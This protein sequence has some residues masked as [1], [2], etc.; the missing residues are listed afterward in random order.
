[1]IE[2]FIKRIAAN[3]E[4]IVEYCRECSS[5]K[6]AHSY[7][8]ITEKYYDLKNLFFTSW[9]KDPTKNRSRSNISKINRITIDIDF[10]KQYKAR[11][12]KDI[13]DEEIIGIWMNI[14][15]MLREEY[16]DDYW[17]WNFIVFSWN[18][19]HIHYIWNIYEIKSEKDY[20]LFRETT[21]D[22]YKWF[23]QIMWDEIFF[24]DEKVWDLWHL[25][26]VP[27]TINEKEWIKHECKIIDYQNI[28]SD[29]VNNLNLL[30]KLSDNRIKKRQE[31]FKLKQLEKQRNEIS[32]KKY[33]WVNAFEWINQ[34]VDVA[35]V[36]QILIP[37]RK[38]KSDKKNFCNPAKWSNVNASYFVDR[39]NNVLIR[40][41]STKLPWTKEWL[42][43]VSL[44]MEWFWFKWKEC[45][46][47]F[48]NNK[49]ISQDILN[50][51]K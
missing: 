42:N 10:R 2:E 38:L 23:N 18:W 46:E 35:E 11:Y 29:V 13:T 33:N 28:D 49:F 3:W 31:E 24:A 19:L 17:Q 25:F 44:V 51:N 30:M 32:T 48:V 1:M 12:W 39:A 47:W 8:D 50:N 14:W 22:F 9:I 27:W 37:E 20:D 4:M 16:P 45:I 26:R 6:K 5:Q 7:N 40:N 34:N 36:I 15:K 43:P 41:G 21:L